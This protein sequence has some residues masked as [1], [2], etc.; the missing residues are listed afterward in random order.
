MPSGA[1]YHQGSLHVV[2]Q[3][4]CRLF[5]PPSSCIG[6]DAIKPDANVDASKLQQQ[7]LPVVRQNGNAA[8]EGPVVLHEAYGATGEVLSV[9]V[10]CI[11]V[12]DGDRTATVDV[13]KNGTTILTAPIVLDSA[14]VAYTHESAVP[15]VTA[16]VA[17]DVLTVTVTVAGSSGTHVTGLWVQA[18]IRETAQ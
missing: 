1:T 16:L 12:P 11:T 7:Y 4:S 3:L 6:N 17:G 5:S 14:N 13:K 18:V 15:S 10:G 8:A 9:R 2:D